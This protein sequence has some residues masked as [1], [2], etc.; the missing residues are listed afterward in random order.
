MHKESDSLFPV[1]AF[2]EA[3]FCWALN[4]IWRADGQILIQKDNFPF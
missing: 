2:T 1:S 4:T 3:A